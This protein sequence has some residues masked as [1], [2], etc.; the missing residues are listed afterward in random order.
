MCKGVCMCVYVC[1]CVCVYGHVAVIGEKRNVYIE[2][3]D[4]SERKKPLG[5]PRSR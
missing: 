4:K 1:V 2:L 5:R 3:V